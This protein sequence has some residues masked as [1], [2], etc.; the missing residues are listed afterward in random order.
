MNDLV[1]II[2]PCY[3]GEKFIDRC[4][5][6][7]LNQD[8]PYIQ[9][10][11]VNDGSTDH[12]EQHVL[13]WGGKFKDAGMELVYISQENRGPGGAI[14]TGLKAVSGEFLSLLDVDDEFM[15]SAISSRVVFLNE[16]KNIDVV[17][18]NGWYNRKSGKSLFIYDDAEKKIEDV[19]TALVAANTNNWAGTYMVRT[20]ALFEF[21]PDREIYQSRYGQNLQFLMPLTYRKKCGFIDKPQMNYNIQEESL[22]QTSDPQMEMERFLENGAGYRDIR[23]HMIKQVVHDS[24]EVQKYVRM[25]DVAY[26]RLVLNKAVSLKDKEITKK[27]YTDLK[28]S[29]AITINDRINY[30]SVIFPC[31]VLPLRCIRKLKSVLRI[32]T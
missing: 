12:S 10:I 21:Y 1:S 31:A 28:R 17:R 29:R 5:N 3:N 23:V 22:S 20:S 13:S 18:S 4:F 16:H 30:Y 32:G 9:I 15:E 24:D 26:Y 27:V 11:A 25:A 8:Y 2:V 7:I 14:N 19:F 6:S